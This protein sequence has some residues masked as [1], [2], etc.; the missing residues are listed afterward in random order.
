MFTKD[1]LDKEKHDDYTTLKTVGFGFCH[2]TSACST[3]IRH[4]VWFDY[5]DG[6][7]ELFFGHPESRPETL[8]VSKFQSATAY[9]RNKQVVPVEIN[10]QDGII[11]D[12]Q[13]EVKAGE[14]LPITVLYEG[15]QIQDALVEYLGKE[16]DMNEQGIA[17]IPI[18]EG[19]LQVIEASYDNPPAMNLVVSHATT[20]TAEPIPE[21]SALLGLSTFG[22]IAF[23][24]KSR[25]K[26][27]KAESGRSA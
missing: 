4:T 22:L 23:I 21:P 18:G 9:D 19:E 17:F 13:F 25:L 10:K 16:V 27:S 14:T 20:F 3:S 8:E 7:Y 26:R 24:G 5:K 11:V 15:N 2:A 1:N 12:P 6:E